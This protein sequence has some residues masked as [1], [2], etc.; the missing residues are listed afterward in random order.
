[1]NIQDLKQNDK[2][3]ALKNGKL[4][5]TFVVRKWIDDRVVLFDDVK[6]NEL[7]LTLG[8]VNQPA[9][10][11]NSSF[12]LVTLCTRKNMKYIGDKK[13]KNLVI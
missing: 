9:C 2:L 3:Y 6:F 5:K 4:I 7:I 1:M 12:G 11:I 13:W 8:N 10:S